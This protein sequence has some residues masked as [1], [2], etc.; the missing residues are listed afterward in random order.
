MSIAHFRAEAA[1]AGVE[2]EIQNH[3]LM[4]DLTGRLA[5][6][7]GR[8]AGSTNPFIVGRANYPVF[9]DVMSEC[10]QA[11]IGRRAP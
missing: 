10:M 3:P 1:K 9:L 11:Q 6:L 2:V 5:Q 7:R 4:D 8:A